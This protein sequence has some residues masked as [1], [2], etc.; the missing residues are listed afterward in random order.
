MFKNKFSLNF[1]IFTWFLLIYKKSDHMTCMT[2]VHFYII[3][4]NNYNISKYLALT[5]LF[6]CKYES[7]S[8]KKA[9]LFL[10]IYLIK[11]LRLLWLV[12]V[13]KS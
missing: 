11:I 13:D 1:F 10:F 5:L 7:M 4:K 6:L 12:R 3:K 8:K 2:C 9:I